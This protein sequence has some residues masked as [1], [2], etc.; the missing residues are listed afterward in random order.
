MHNT[1]MVKNLKFGTPKKKKAVI[2]PYHRLGHCTSQLVK[3][4]NFNLSLWFTCTLFLQLS[5]CQNIHFCQLVTSWSSFLKVC[6]KISQLPGDYRIAFHPLIHFFSHSFIHISDYRT[7][8]H[9][10]IHFFSHSFIHISHSVI[11]FI[12][13]FFH[14][15]IIYSFIFRLFV[16]LPSHPPIP[17][18]T[19]PPACPPISLSYLLV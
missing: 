8:F 12:L 14:L 10:F 18:P 9:P 2:T 7:A 19:H 15:F 16:Y 4:I 3:L 13:S 6:P 5:L 17:P 11:S 1:C